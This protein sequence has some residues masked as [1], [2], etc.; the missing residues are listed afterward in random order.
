MKFK[1]GDKIIATKKCSYNFEGA[2]TRAGTIVGI[3]NT[4]RWPYDVLFDDKNVFFDHVT[5]PCNE[6]EIELLS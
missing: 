6:D 1:V 5:C 4:T 3:V 2:T